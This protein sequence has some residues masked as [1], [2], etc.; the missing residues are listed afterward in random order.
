MSSSPKVILE[1]L[2]DDNIRRVVW[3]YCD[4]EK[5]ESAQSEPKVKVCCRKFHDDNNLGDEFFYYPAGI[6]NLGQVPLGTIFR[7]HNKIG[8]LDKIDRNNIV[9][10]IFQL[11]FDE[12]AW[13]F[14][15]SWG[16]ISEKSWIIPPFSYSLPDRSRHLPTKI[17]SFHLTS[18]PF[19][20]IIP[21]LVMFSRLYGRSQYV[22]RVLLT[23]PF[24]VAIDKLIVPDVEE[25]PPDTWQVTM[26]KHCYDGDG[27]FL[28]HIRHDPVT[29][30]RVRSIWGQLEGAQDTRGTTQIFPEI[31]P[32][33]DGAVQLHV[34]GL[35]LDKD[36][37]RFLALQILRWSDPG[38]V[39]IYLDRQNTNL[40]TGPLKKL[41][42]KTT[43]PRVVKRR[44]KEQKELFL[45]YSEEPGTGLNARE[46]LDA[47]Y[48]GLGKR[49]KVTKI[50]RN[51]QGDREKGSTLLRDLADQCSGGEAHGKKEDVDQATIHAPEKVESQGTLKDAWNALVNLATDSNYGIKSVASVS[52]D[53]SISNSSEP[54]TFTFSDFNIEKGLNLRKRKWLFLDPTRPI[55]KRKSRCM[56]LA[57]VETEL[58]IGYLLEIQRRAKIST[59]GL[60]ED[61]DKF[62]GFAFRLENDCDL[63][64][65]LPSFLDSLARAKGI[66][67]N[68]LEFRP[69]IAYAYKHV[70]DKQGSLKSAV[71]NALSKIKLL[72]QNV[73]GTEVCLNSEDSKIVDSQK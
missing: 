16:K 36:K 37:T 2:P 66:F 35:W 56:L 10:E 60:L 40:V 14:A 59:E 33:H 32:W 73:N 58:G 51:Q 69:K 45:R 48:G 13:E 43:W 49:R 19:G 41:R 12:N 15:T 53:C 57:R 23:N 28:A 7:G 20:L 64:V 65:W 24:D 25:A 55:E 1:G 34:K 21:C 68:A 17:A 6:T 63:T 29:E 31:G 39:E 18:T 67:D 11:D 54:I 30:K 8:Q 72:G 46:I 47:P 42:D 71:L 5:N 50:V 9:E 70:H 26:D 61:T 27:I 3:W 62:K 52:C 44:P 4:L 22:K 38:G